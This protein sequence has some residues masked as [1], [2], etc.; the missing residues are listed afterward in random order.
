MKTINETRIEAIRIIN[1]IITLK[2]NVMNGCYSDKAE[3]AIEE[4]RL[5]SIKEWAIANEQIQEI[6]HYLISKNFGQT[7]QFAATE[8]SA[9]F[10]N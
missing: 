7:C 3:L 9:Y 4:K 10:H 8:I 6:R 5:T 2:A 1:K